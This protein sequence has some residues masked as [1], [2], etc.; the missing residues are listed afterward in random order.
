MWLKDKSRIIFSP[1]YVQQS[2]FMEG[3]LNNALSFMA[4]TWHSHPCLHIIVDVTCHVDGQ[5]QIAQNCHWQN[6]SKNISEA[7]G[8][9]LVPIK[10]RSPVFRELVQSTRQS[11]PIY[12]C[13]P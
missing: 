9:N 10:R 1:L 7:W 5:M 12:P 6:Y 8:G 3:V 4:Q 2:F 13:M 11:P